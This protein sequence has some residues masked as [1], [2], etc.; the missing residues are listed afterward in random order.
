MQQN[1]CYDVANVASYG[2][3]LLYHLYELNHAA[4]APMRAMAEFGKSFVTNSAS[5]FAETAYGRAMAAGFDVFERTTRRYDKPE[6][7]ITCVEIDGVDIAVEQRTVWQHPFCNLLH[8]A[9]AKKTPT[10]SHS[11]VLIVAPMSGHHAT[12]LRGTVGRLLKDH[13][14]YITDWIDARDVPASA[15]RFDLDDYIDTLIKIFHHLGGHTHVIAVC[16]PSV[17]VM[18]AVALMNEDNDAHAPATMTLMGGPVDTRINPTAVNTFAMERGT[19]WFAQNA[20]VDVPASHAGAG[21]RVYPGFAQLSGFISMNPDR[22][23]KAHHALFYNLVE[24]DDL[25]AEKHR[26]FYDEYLSVMDLDA[27]YYL[28][29]VDTVFVSHLLPKGEMRHRSRLI[30]LTAIRQ[31]ALMT[32]EGERDDISGVGQTRAAHQLCCNLAKKRKRH[33]SQAGIGHYGVFSGTV[34]DREIAPRISRFIADNPEAKH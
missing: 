12:L 31:T 26:A 34:F 8:F 29:T 6:F 25:S 3:L 30:D 16:Q 28:Q 2:G 22:H 19:D 4:M 21:R 10:Q 32:V 13:D 9:K 15:G 14:V 33:H 23:L 27:D 5:P 24:G 20:I 1:S 11:P 17:P 18:A 7:G